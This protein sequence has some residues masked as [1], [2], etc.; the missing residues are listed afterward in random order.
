M[1]VT[2][3]A[4]R[5]PTQPAPAPGKAI[6]TFK[7]AVNEFDNQ[8]QAVKSQ[9]AMALPPQIPSDKF[10]G[11]VITAVNLE[12]DL[13]KADRRSLLNACCQAAKDGL[14]PDKRE[15]ALVI[16][17]TKEKRDGQ[18]VWIKKVQWMPMVYGI[19]K[20]IR[21][22]GEIAAVNAKIVYE[23]ETRPPVGPK[24]LTLTDDRGRPL[25]PAFQYVIADGEERIEH[26]PMLWGD[27]GDMVL[28]YAYAK[29][30]DGHTEYEPLTKADIDK[31]RSVS[32]S[33]DRGPWVD[34][35][36]EMAKK[37]AIRRLSKRLPLSAELHDQIQRE[38]GPTEFDQ[39][40]DQARKTLIGKAAEQLGAPAKNGNGHSEV[41]EGEVEDVTDRH[42]PE[43]GEV[44]D[45]VQ[46][47]EDAG[48][49]VLAD[50]SSDEAE[51]AFARG[52]RLLALCTTDRDI[53]D[54]RA[55]ISDELPEDQ[56][57]TWAIACDA[58]QTEIRKPNGNGK[59]K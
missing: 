25:P 57:Q 51:P 23:A 32:K 42:D 2:E 34:W 52:K 45:D 3:T 12:P 36:E 18:D 29:F 28:A 4:A 53:A 6:V 59:K 5:K 14:Q 9:W 21:Q 8:L 16:F 19:I 27:R 15:G 7:D 55:S 44:T 43:T 17:N 20:K 30:K 33:K 10:R 38:D 49:G 54:L 31:I 35:Y 47:T 13:L 22:S 46:Q 11:V 58:R 26:H 48:E 24:G 1:S 56:Q 50:E 41:I 39:L 37:S 40:R